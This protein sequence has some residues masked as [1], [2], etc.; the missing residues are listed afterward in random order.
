MLPVIM[1]LS[2]HVIMLLCHLFTILSSHKVSMSSFLCFQ[3]SNWLTINWQTNN[4]RTALQTN[5]EEEN[6][7]NVANFQFLLTYC[8]SFCTGIWKS[9]QHQWSGMGCTVCSPSVSFSGRESL[10]WRQKMVCLFPV[11]ASSPCPCLCPCLCPYLSFSST[12][13]LHFVS[14]GSMLLLR[15]HFPHQ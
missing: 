7:W 5:I 15:F 3:H 8:I 9:S 4:I 10:S 13:R 6:E 11:F 1:S 2:H 12:V 14:C